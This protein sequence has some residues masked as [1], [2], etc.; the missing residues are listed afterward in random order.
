MKKDFVTSLK[1]NIPAGVSDF[2]TTPISEIEEIDMPTSKDEAVLACGKLSANLNNAFLLPFVGLT[3]IEL[4]LRIGQ[5]NPVMISSLLGSLEVIDSAGGKLTPIAPAD[6]GVYPNYF[7]LSCSGVGLTSVVFVV[8]GSDEISLSADGKIWK[9]QPTLP[10]ST[11]AHSGAFVG[12][13]GDDS[14]VTAAVK[15]KTTANMKIVSTFPENETSYYP[16]DID[17]IDIELSE[18]PGEGESLTV[19]IFDYVLQPAIDG[20]HVV[21]QL[22]DIGVI[23]VGL[24]VMTVKNAAGEILD[25]ITF[26]INPPEA[27]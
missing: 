11:G 12:T 9:G 6:G 25:T 26:L 14:S 1:M 19:T 22:A 20:V 27:E 3:P 17:H 16:A 4:M 2:L 24:N 7:E 15:F 8:E 5:L 13:F 18:A 23:W 10:F 21:A